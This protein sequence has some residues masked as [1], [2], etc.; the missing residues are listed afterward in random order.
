MLP[1]LPSYA[2]FCAYY[3]ALALSANIL[4]RAGMLS[5]AHAGFSAVGA[6][7][8][9]AVWTSLD[10]ARTVT[11]PSAALGFGAA[12][13][14]GAV[15]A[16]ALGLITARLEGDAVLVTTLLFVYMLRRGVEMMPTLGG[17]SGIGVSVFPSLSGQARL[18]VV[19]GIS[20]A[21][22]VLTGL[23]LYTFRRSGL[24]AV[25]DTIRHD[26]QS[27][28]VLGLHVKRIRVQLF[29]L[30]GIVAAGGG[31]VYVLFKQYAAPSSFDLDLAI[32]VFVMAL[33]G[34][35]RG[36]GGSVLGACVLFLTPEL[37]RIPAWR[38]PVR[39]GSLD[40]ITVAELWPLLFALVI[41]R[42][43]WVRADVD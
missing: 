21:W 9:I 41:I 24:G 22:A 38:L 36:L 35:R 23:L 13:L 6:F 28:G 12:V 7:T 15:F 25:L 39:I 2:F 4:L 33:V 11:W 18:G 8:A 5:V 31:C 19:A 20:V 3:V 30:S 16:V 10:A 17:A 14:T 29:V 40:S 34:K 42:L 1:L 32:L 43:A 26:P 27:A 37:L